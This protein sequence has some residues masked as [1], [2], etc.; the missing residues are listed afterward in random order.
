MIKLRTLVLTALIAAVLPLTGLYASSQ[1][2]PLQASPG[3]GLF[4]V[5]TDIHFNPFTDAALVPELDRQPVSAWSAIFQSGDDAIQS[6]GADAGHALMTSAFKAA[7]S[8]SMRYDYVLYT[9]D[10]LG[11]DFN[12]QYDK[13]AGPSPEGVAPFAVKTARYVS[14]LLSE[15]IPG[16]PVFGVM[17]N[18]DAACGDYE[19][20]PNGPFTK[21]LADQWATLSGQPDRFQ[22]FP[23]SGSYKVAHPTVPGQ[24]ILVLNNIFWTPRYQ[25]TCNPSGGDPGA[26]M[27]SWLEREIE[28]VRAA[29]RKTQILL[30]VPPGINAYS[31]LKNDGTCQSRI[32]PFWADRFSEKFIALM[33]Q[34][35]D[36]VDYTFSGHT[37][38]DSFAIVTASEG[39]P[40]VASQITPAVSPIFGNNPAFAVFLYDRSTGQIEDSATFYLSNLEDAANG[41]EP[42]WQPEYDYRDTYSLTDLSPASRA[43]LARS[44]KTNAAV[45]AR[46]S[47]LYA[48][49]AK[50]PVTD[51]TWTAYACAQSALT[52]DAFATCYCDSN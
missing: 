41:A 35:G 18:T 28:A 24:D 21:G 8:Q 47:D 10:Y 43:A 7:A 17:G 3:Q 13:M 50:S 23:T 29:G 5:V 19:I 31:T 16:A 32:A 1:T 34:Y 11:H 25:D 6:Y 38:M 22:D 26:A 4:L 49:K 27:M 52:R 46:F 36:V 30:H 14:R 45:R 51:T 44:I 42:V 40:L 39:T 12:A 2:A 9:G 20:A 33:R 15:H 48:V 37:H